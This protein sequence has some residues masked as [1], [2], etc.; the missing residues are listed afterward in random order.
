[1]ALV[2]PSQTASLSLSLGITASSLFASGSE[3]AAPE[4]AFLYLALK[5]APVALKA[6]IFLPYSPPTTPLKNPP[7]FCGSK[8]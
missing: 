3:T 6:C 4:I 5:S 1:M 8:L 2:L 7:I